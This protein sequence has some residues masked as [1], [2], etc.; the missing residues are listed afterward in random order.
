MMRDRGWGKRPVFIP[1]ETRNIKKMTC[2]VCGKTFYPKAEYIARDRIT[3]GGIVNAMNG[4]S[5][6]PKRYDAMDC[7]ECGCQMILKTRLD[8]VKNSMTE[9]ACLREGK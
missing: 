7:P 9:A 5:D 8:N 4:N 3:K 2:T 6:E 1:E